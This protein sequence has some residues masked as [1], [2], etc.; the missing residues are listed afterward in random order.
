VHNT[1]FPLD[2]PLH[3]RLLVLRIII[4]NTI[5]Y[6]KIILSLP[7]VLLMVSRYILVSMTTL[8]I[9][10]SLLVALLMVSRYILVSMTT[11]VYNVILS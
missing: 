2:L 3:R 7:V 11:I 8:K 10:L 1:T 6:L 5:P 4:G 9:I